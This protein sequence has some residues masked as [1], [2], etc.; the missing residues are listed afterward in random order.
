MH[1]YFG[2]EAGLAFH[3][4]V[5]DPLSDSKINTL[6]G[7]AT[8]SDA[9]TGQLLFYTDGA[10]VWN[11][12]HQVMVNGSGLNGDRTT[13]Q[14]A[15]IVPKP[16]NP[17]VFYIFSPAAH[18]TNNLR[19]RCLC[20]YYSV[21]DLQLQEGAGEVV[22]KNKL[23]VADITEH[24]TA[25]E[26][27]GGDGY[28]VV[29]RKHGSR[30]FNSFLVDRN[31][32]AATPVVSDA[33]LPLNAPGTA[34]HMQ[35]S[36][37]A[38]RLIISSMDGSSHLY[39]F[40]NGQGYVSAGMELK[41]LDS[42]GIHYGAAFSPA[43]NHCFVAVTDRSMA[44]ARIYQFATR[45]TATE[46]N[47]SQ[48]VIATM[49]NVVSGVP[50]QTAMDGRIYVG[51]P[52]SRKIGVIHRPNRVSDSVQWHSDFIVLPVGTVQQGLPNFMGHLFRPPGTVPPI[53]KAPTASMSVD[54]HTV[55]PNSFITFSDQSSD[56]AT[57]WFWYF[58][59]GSPL[60]YR[61]RQPPPIHYNTVGSHRVRLIA[62]N[63]VGADT[64]YLNISVWPKPKVT[65]HAS[66]LACPG[67]WITLRAEGAD[68]YQWFPVAIFDNPSVGAPRCKLITDMRL[69]VIGTNE[70]G[71]MDTAYVDVKVPHFSLSPSTTIC[72]GDTVTLIASGAD[73]YLW[74]PSDFLSNSQSGST[75]AAP[76]S[77][78]TYYVSMTKG[79]CTFVDSVTVFVKD[80]LSVS[81]SA[82]TSICRG[83]TVQLTVTGGSSW[84]WEPAT[85]LSNVLSEA[86]L[87][88]P[89]T[90]TTYKVTVRSGSCVATEY[91]T[92]TVRLHSSVIHS[93]DSTICIGDTAVL[94]V[95]YDSV[96]WSGPDI[97]ETI[98]NK[99]IRI[100]PVHNSVYYFENLG[101]G[102]SCGILDSVSILVTNVLSMSAGPDLNICPGQITRLT[103]SGPAKGVYRWT[104]TDGLDNPNSIA[105][106]ASP[107]RTTKYFLTG[108]SG[109]CSALD[110]VTVFVS[111][112]N[113]EL[114]EDTSICSGQSVELLVKGGVRYRWSP[115]EGLSD[116]TI[117]NPV[118][119]PTVTTRYSV[120][121]TD[122]H[123]CV[124]TGSVVVTV[125]PSTSV[126]A[127]VGTIS[128]AAGE[129]NVGIPIYM[130]ADT[131][132][133]PLQLGMVQ[134]ELRAAR[135]V[136]YP[137]GLSDRG[138]VTPGMQ[139]NDV[140]LIVT[141]PD[142][143]LVTSN[144]KITEIRGLVLAGDQTVTPF[145]WRWLY[146][147]NVSCSS[148]D[149]VNGSL[150]VTGCF[151]RAR[152]FRSFLGSSVRL[153][154]DPDLTLLK[155]HLDGTE[156]GPHNLDLSDIN[157]R[158]LWSVGFMRDE[159]GAPLTNEVD[160]RTLSNG[161]Y[162]FR[163]TTTTGIYTSPFFIYR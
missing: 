104:P 4:G 106:N 131:R 136:F 61:G 146:L 94:W 50:M 72:P 42:N 156:S 3:S 155:I 74:T 40:D 141:I 68:F 67:Q 137:T 96:R 83:D 13:S 107:V 1:W 98:D 70:Y 114:T 112:L 65:V 18:R 153:E 32:V 24:L 49:P 139:G 7:C 45:G 115:P 147:G 62:Q 101:N 163:L 82:D 140:V 80:T 79:A 93:P 113:L 109:N 55:C 144:Q 118:A 64:A 148:L 12:Y 35:I 29:V 81:I 88:A 46:I 20:L 117:A 23:L 44:I 2:R 69:T 145:H 119:R 27:C 39:D 152:A 66:E 5:A 41:T 126:S 102:S 124:S 116:V 6:E 150:H 90:T 58:A 8:Q 132:L 37:R 100:N 128:A 19:D 22:E 48:S 97:I 127:R 99:S 121:S 73:S 108:S 154:T 133:F 105:P 15:V 86:P 9:T 143:T 57:D 21:V 85:G 95:Q 129:S 38:D 30:Y 158:S 75:Q 151:I 28:W 14:S 43:S 103:A 160:L 142:V 60:S 122:L 125:T 120:T 78:I 130:N 159:S 54:N 92:V 33:G 138:S 161:M 25:V 123:G 135:S 91:V 76:P 111:D 11:R 53:C 16:G 10:T 162:F 51:V 31:G 17:F 77:T 63:Y 34:G 87:A 71:C 134:F 56:D 59:G 52:G 157:G 89:D 47:A 36:P 84:L 149:T 110:S 26:R